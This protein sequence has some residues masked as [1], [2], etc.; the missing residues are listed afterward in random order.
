MG[1]F[2]KFMEVHTCYDLIPTSTKV[3]VFDTELL[4]IFSFLFLFF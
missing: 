1:V 2:K 4:V 3:V